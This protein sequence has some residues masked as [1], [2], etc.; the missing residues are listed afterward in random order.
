M[1]PR[2]V[3]WNN[4]PAPYMVERFNA[5]AGRGNLDFEAWFSARTETNRSWTVDE[6]V[7]GFPYRYLPTVRTPKY[8]ASLPEPLLGRTVPD[9]LVSLY[10]GADFLLGWVL[11]R[12]RGARTAFWAEV[13]HDSVVPRRPWKETL[14]R[15]IFPRVDAVLTAGREGSQ[16]AMRYG[17]AENRIFIVPHV[18]DFDHYFS[19]SAAA[20]AERHTLRA[21]L[22]LQGV[23]FLYVGRLS[24]EKGLDHLLDA[25]G[26]L[27]TRSN[28]PTSLLLVGDGP[29]EARLRKRTQNEGLRNVVFSGFRQKDLLPELYAAADVFVFPTL[30]DTFGLVVTEAMSCSLPVVATSATGEIRDRVAEGVTGF[31]VPPANSAALLD[32]MHMLLE[33]GLRRQI[34]AAAAKSVASQTPAVWA[35]AFEQSI[36]QIL[37]MARV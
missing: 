6:A 26:V 15:H 8:H 19:R 22:G 35:Q 3:Y 24:P 23:T 25:F 10:A 36:E 9:V 29:E 21:T 20:A 30:G 12:Q 32:R 31:I 2:V 7:W 13:T 18:V 16:F 11:A 27:Q 34:G 33:E 28:T 37:T 4:I 17:A 5:L 14:K 1:K